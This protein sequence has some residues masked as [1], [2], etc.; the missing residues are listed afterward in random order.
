M[1]SNMLRLAVVMSTM[2][3]V[4]AACEICEMLG[5]DDIQGK[6]TGLL[7]GNK[8]Y[9]VG[10]VAL[11]WDMFENETIGLTHPFYHDLR[12]RGTGIATDNA[13]GTGN[14][15]SGWEWYRSTKV[16][17]GTVVTEEMRWPNPVPA[18]MFWRPDKMVVEYELVNPLLQGTFDGWCQ[19][20]KEG[21]SAGVGLGKSFFVNLTETRCWSRCNDDPVCH[22]AVYEGGATTAEGQCFLGLTQLMA[23]QT[24]SGPR[25]G[26]DADK[27]CH[28][29][30]LATGAVVL[31]VNIT[32]EKFISGND[33][34]STIITSSRPITMAFS[35][36]SFAGG[37]GSGKIVSLNGRCSMDG[38]SNTLHVLEGGVA[39]AMVGQGP[40][41]FK[42]GPMVLDGMSAVISASRPLD[43]VTIYAEPNQPSGVCGYSFYVPVDQK[44]TTLSWTMNDEHSLAVAAVQEVIGTTQQQ[45]AEKTAHVDDLLS[46]VVPF[47]NCSDP[48]VV[49]LYYFLW[50]IYLG[51]YTE[52]DRGMQN[53]LAHTQTAINNFMGM[54]RYD[55]VFQII[56]GS[57]TTPDRHDYYANGN[58]MV[59]NQTMPYRN[60]PALPDNFGIDWV[61]GCYGEETIAHVLGAWQTFEHSGNR[62]FLEQAY[63]FY[64][65]LFWNEIGGRNFGQAYDSVLA[66]NSMATTLGYHNDSAHWNAS[67]DMSGVQDMLAGSWEKDTKCFYGPTTAPNSMGWGAVA[68]SGMSMFPR[69]WTKLM[70]HRWLD[71]TVDGFSYGEQPLLCTARKSWPPGAPGSVD[72]ESTTYN[73][74]TTPDANWYMLRGLYRHTIDG[75]ANKFTLA[76]LKQYN[77]NWGGIPVAPETRRM[78]YAVHGDQYS[79][80]NAGKILLILEGIGGLKYSTEADSFTFADN[81]P[82]EWGFM[83]FKVPVQKPGQGHVQWVTARSERREEAGKVT[84]TVTVEGNPF[85]KLVVQPWGEDLQ[86]VSSQPAGDDPNAPGGHLGWN[87]NAA[88]ATVV[89]T[90]DASKPSSDAAYDPAMCN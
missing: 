80:F 30:C 20:W 74:V 66:L 60:G 89:I 13:T 23:G 19:D 61:S 82:T 8:V 50:S 49:K 69:N 76:H 7:T 53:G 48:D 25:P 17:Y 35:G 54:H 46:N 18:R 55:A 1:H 15:F 40:D 14:D 41:V 78:N 62:T 83:E 26:C 37:G 16:A 77:M 10:G 4:A 5:Q 56:V 63:G 28:D 45:L 36:H 65:E 47:F 33:V 84:K 6:K 72:P 85:G 44:S 29:T 75:L 86:V 68:Y 57:W 31:P 11:V 12:S 2:L 39:S 88:N 64:K 22:Q 90:L 70:A 52:G 9:Y 67:L 51:Y 87:F 38:S 42:D 3:S 73:F 79:N 21:S 27:G 71:D 81:L 34:V 59:W 58:V 43:N 24:P 32:E